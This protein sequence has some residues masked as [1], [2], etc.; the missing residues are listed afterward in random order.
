MRRTDRMYEPSD[1][2]VLME[3]IG[4]RASSWD[5]VLR[6]LDGPAK[7]ETGLSS[8]EV[9]QLA[10]DVRDL[11]QDDRHFTTD[12]SEV[13]RELSEPHGEAAALDRSPSAT[14]HADPS[15]RVMDVL[16]R[17]QS[18]EYR[19]LAGLREPTRHDSRP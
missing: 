15:A 19:E 9:Q 5:D 1:V 10:D 7:A 4:S 3:K 17:V 2:K 18:R 11:K 16:R 12:Y 8:L 13:W 14:Q 6:Y